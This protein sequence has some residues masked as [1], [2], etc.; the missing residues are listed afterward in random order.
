MMGKLKKQELEAPAH[1]RS[2]ARKQRDTNPFLL[3]FSLLFS[4][5]CNLRTPAQGMVLSRGKIGLQTSI[6]TFKMTPHR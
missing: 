2:I 6:N 3:V 5:L 1:F 4:I